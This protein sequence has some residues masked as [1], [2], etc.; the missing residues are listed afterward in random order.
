MELPRILPPDPAW[1]RDRAYLASML[2]TLASAAYVRASACPLPA[3]TVEAAGDLFTELLDDLPTTPDPISLTVYV[4]PAWLLQATE[5]VLTM[6]RRARDE[7]EAA[8]LWPVQELL[9]DLEEH[10]G[11]ARR[12]SRWWTIWRRWPPSCA[13]TP[14]RCGR[15]RP[16]PSLTACA[17]RSS[18]RPP[19]TC[20]PRGRLSASPAGRAAVPTVGEQV[21]AAGP[22][23]GDLPRPA[24][25]RRNTLA[26]RENVTTRKAP[27]HGSGHP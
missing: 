19:Q 9:R 12:W 18:V 26:S 15:W 13:S 11:R 3:L 16:V 8:E 21:P 7:R 20:E 22:H 24:L 6:L 23:C 27:S 10:G 4:V 1:L 2:K 17:P 14:R 25:S 5:D